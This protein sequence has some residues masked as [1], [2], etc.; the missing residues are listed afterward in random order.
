MPLKIGPRL[1]AFID[2]PLPLVVGTLLPNASGVHMLPTWYEFRD[3][4]FWVN[5][6]YWPERGSTARWIN[7]LMSGAHGALYLRDHTDPFRWARIDAV[8]QDQMPGP[9]DHLARL[10]QRYAASPQPYP[11]VD[12]Q[13]VRL[14]PLGV[15]AG[16]DRAQYWDDQG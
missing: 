4:L 6:L 15:T 10:S 16:S 2:L 7:N 12:Q 14:N 11:L 8:M 9:P 5:A 1:R 13:T 3:G